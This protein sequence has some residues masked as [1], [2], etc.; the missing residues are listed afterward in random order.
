MTKQEFEQRLGKQVNSADYSIIEYVYN[1]HPS[2]GEIGGKDQI[3]DLYQLGGMRLIKDMLP[4]AQKAEKLE[5]EIR[6]TRTT[7]ETLKKQY[8]AL[9]TGAE[10]E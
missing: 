4:T 6:K 9:K 8:E 3:S 10:E 7:L 2:I 1:F 5:D